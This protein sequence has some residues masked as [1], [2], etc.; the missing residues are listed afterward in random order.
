[1]GVKLG[2]D[3]TLATL[4]G[5]YAVG[6]LAYDAENIG[7]GR[8]YTIFFDGAGNWRATLIENDNGTLSDGSIS[9]SYS[10]TSSGALTLSQV[11]GNAHSGAISADGNILVAANLTGGANGEE[12]RIFVGFRQ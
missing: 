3:V 10:L 5:V 12:P 7:D 4:N 8:V 2:S 9:G 1:V 6:S 11:N